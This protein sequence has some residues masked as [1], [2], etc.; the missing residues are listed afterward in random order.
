MGFNSI[1]KPLSWLAL[2]CLLALSPICLVAQE[3]TVGPSLQVFTVLASIQAVAQSDADLDPFGSPLGSAIGQELTGKDIPIL[4]ALRDF[5]MSHKQ[6]D[7][8]REQ[9]QYVSL[10][11]F[12]GDAPFFDLSEN[13]STLPQEV[14]DLRDMV[15][16]VVDFYQQA[17]IDELWQKYR[18]Q[19][20]ADSEKYRAAMTRIIQEMTGYLRMDPTEFRSRNFSVL[21]NPFAASN[22]TDSRIYENRYY[23]VV[24]PGGA[25]PEEEMRHAWLHYLLDPLPFRNPREMLS[26]SALIKIT[27]RAPALDNAFRDDFDLLLTESLIRAAIVRQSKGNA[28]AKQAAIQQAVQ[29]GFVLGH[30]FFEALETF[31]RQPVGM[32]L[33]FPDMVDEINV[34]DEEKR[35]SAVQF[36]AVPPRPKERIRRSR[37]DEMTRLAEDSIAQGDYESAR[38]ILAP[39]LEQYGPQA[40]VFYSLAI[41]AS[42]QKNAD[43]AKQYFQQAAA[44]SSDPSIKS[45]SHVLLGRLHDLEGNRDSALVEYAAALKIDDAPVETVVAAQKGL[46]ES[47][48]PAGAT[49]PPL[50]Q[51]DPKPRHGVPLGRDVPSTPSTPSNP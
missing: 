19:I 2:G 18:P 46:Q 8:L 20:E 30:Y 50:P 13:P 49:P 5:Y 40:R 1:Q 21:M 39:L 27:Q 9:S 3:I 7:P 6:S 14:W 31:E 33:Y 34:A 4:P 48:A 43:L 16:L 41:I 37:L 36:L 28:A 44:L 32:R 51:E 17:K 12:L 26:K 10:A 35:L 25:V 45:W 22:L 15:P 11:L 38:Q 29:E 47:F 23:L 24:G 42:Q